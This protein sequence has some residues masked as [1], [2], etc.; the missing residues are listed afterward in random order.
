MISKWEFNEISQSEW[1]KFETNYR[2]A[3]FLQSVQNIAMREKMGGYQN[4]IV[5]VRSGKKIIAGGV[6]SGRRGEFWMAYGPL[7]DWNDQKL[8]QFFLRGITSFSCEKNMLKVEIFPNALLTVRDSKGQI[9]E[10]HNQDKM[11]QIFAEA[12]WH[13]QGETVGYE[14]KAGRWA[15]TKDLSG[16]MSV[17]ELRATYRKT[18]RVR[19]R[20][21]DGQVEIQKLKRDDLSKLVGLIDE[22]DAHNGV[23]G[24]ELDYYR[25]MFDA[26]DRDIE[27]LITVKSDDKTPVAGAIFIH[28]GN[29]MASYLS[30]MDRHY[31]NLNGRAWLQD[32]VMQKCLKQGITRINFFW[33]E[34]KFTDNRLLEFK[35]GFGGVVEEYIGGFEKV[36]RPAEY[37]A[38]RVARKTKNLGGRL[39][40]KISN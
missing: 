11:K 16:I 31:R 19:L 6:L 27:F 18:L 33:I 9:L 36:L 34:G 38:R 37:L 29:E 5:G 35:S 40:R 26:F 22:S 24:R 15:F 20:Q 32:Y 1:N 39:L 8:V 14:M 17:N 21:T 7:I 3:H 28:H 30:G 25:A 23:N 2:S 13:Y 10:K 4:Y 12:G